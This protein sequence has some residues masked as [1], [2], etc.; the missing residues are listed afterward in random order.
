MK[1][2]QKQKLVL[3]ADVSSQEIG[4]G[5]GDDQRRQRESGGKGQGPE[6]RHPEQ[7][8]AEELAVMF[9]G[10]MSLCVLGDRVGIGQADAQHLKHRPQVLRQN[11]EDRQRGKQEELAAR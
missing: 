6:E 2:K 9:Q 4:H 8:V 1:Q 7:A 3:A 5:I 11:P 10:E